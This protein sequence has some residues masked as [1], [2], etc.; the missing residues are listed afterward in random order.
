[1]F[2]MLFKFNIKLVF[3]GGLLFS[4]LTCIFTILIYVPNLVA[5]GQ[6][7]RPLHTEK[8]VGLANPVGL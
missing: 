1:M 7:L 3:F 5:I 6:K 2:E 4:N 8:L